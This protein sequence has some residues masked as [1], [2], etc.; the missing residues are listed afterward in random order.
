MWLRFMG[1]YQ[2]IHLISS[3]GWRIR[4]AN[5][6][7]DLCWQQWQK[8]FVI[9]LWCHPVFQS[10]SWGETV[11]V[12]CWCRLLGS[13]PTTLCFHPGQNFCHPSRGQIAGPWFS[14]SLGLQQNP[15]FPF[16]AIWHSKAPCEL[17]TY[18]SVCSPSTLGNLRVVLKLW[19]WKVNCLN[20]FV[21]LM[22]TDCFFSFV[23]DESL[24]SSVGLISQENL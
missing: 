7:W 21:V 6:R 5:I 11:G 9:S 23:S 13:L 10:G 18:Q 24:L 1:T 4:R 2:N 15:Q 14:F 16:W 20:L 12:S 8:L 17:H 19:C 22:A 3:D